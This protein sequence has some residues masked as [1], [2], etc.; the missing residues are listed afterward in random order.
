MPLLQSLKIA[1]LWALLLTYKCGPLNFGLLFST[2]YGVNL[3]RTKSHP[4][5]LFQLIKLPMFF[6]HPP[7][8]STWITTFPA[9]SYYLLRTNRGDL[10]VQL[11]VFRFC[12]FRELVLAYVIL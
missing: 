7:N 10:F 6:P 5:T 12:Y 11:F 4:C 3:S 8:Y 2:Q 9:A 1:T